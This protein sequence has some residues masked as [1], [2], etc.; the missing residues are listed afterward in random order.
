MAGHGAPIGNNYASKAKKFRVA[1]EAV[2]H[3]IDA[4]GR[5]GQTMYE[6]LLSYIADAKTD[7]DVRKDF[8][9]RMFGKPAQA[10]VGGDEDDDPIRF[11]RV[12]K[13]VSAKAADES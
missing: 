5:P 6:I 11:E 2:L 9:D 10:V 8:L 7:K 4:T 12:I 3:D 13:L 1:I